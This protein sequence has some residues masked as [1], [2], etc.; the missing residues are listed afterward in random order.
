MKILIV[1]TTDI[2]GGAARA[3]YRLHRS[4]L[5]E[6]GDSRML[7]QSRT[8]DDHTVI[9]PQGKIAKSFKRI[10]PMLDHLPLKFYPDKTRTIFS[11]AWVPFSGIADKV[12]ALNPDVVHLHWICDGMMRIEELAKIHAPIVWSLHDMWAFTGGCHYDEECGG[13]KRSCGKCKVLGS[14]DANDISARIWARKQKIYNALSNLTVVG[15]SRW[16]AGAASEST[17]FRNSRVVNLPNPI[18]TEIFAPF[19]KAQARDLLNLPQDKKLV[20][21][22]GMNANAD[23]RKGFQELGASLAHLDKNDAELMV[24]GSNENKESWGFRQQVHYMGQLHDDVALR[25][26]Y[27]AADAT[28][29]PSLQENLSNVIME[30]LACGTPVVGFDV[31]GNSDLIEHKQNGYLANP[32]DVTELAAGIRWTL[33]DVKNNNALNKNARNKVL[34]CFES[35]R[36]AKRYWKLY[37]EVV[38]Q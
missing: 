12:N 16:L 3:A 11:P 1:N 27:N 14:E 6:D 24:L 29:A 34:E 38:A 9:G 31:G 30:S 21:F 13:Y 18:N 8:S 23:P 28:V 26:L 17:I 10:R 5:T 32:F 15:L 25:L 19:S 4:L 35:H 7:V 33:E 2:H 36:V 37:K 20:L 22:G